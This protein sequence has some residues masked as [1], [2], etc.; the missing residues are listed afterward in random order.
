MEAVLLP[1]LQGVLEGRLREFERSRK[2][3][4]GDNQ[5]NCCLCHRK[6]E[7]KGTWIRGNNA[8]PLRKGRC[9]DICNE[10]K[11]I[12]ARLNRAIAKQKEG[13]K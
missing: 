1:E 2:E 12:Q 11:V 10:T 5:M 7:R 3:T 4:K 13:G 8:E 9:C 6:I